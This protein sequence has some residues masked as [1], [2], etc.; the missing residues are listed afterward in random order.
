MTV[1]DAAATS[2]WSCASL[3]DA[4]D[5]NR[6]DSCAKC[7]RDSRVCK[8]CKH[9]DPRA[10]NECHETSADRV[11]EKERANFCDYF[12][13]RVGPATG[14]SAEPTAAEKA[15]AA[16]EALFKNLGKK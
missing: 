4:G 9:Y 6:G 5:F 16:A 10:Y 3:I 11:V 7:G 2:C 8:N 13:R 14:T 15:K 12:S 1:S